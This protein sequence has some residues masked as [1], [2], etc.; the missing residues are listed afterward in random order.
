[1]TPL[2]LQHTRIDGLPSLCPH[3]SLDPSNH[4]PRPN[5]VAP[6]IRSDCDRSGLRI[7]SVPA[8]DVRRRR[9]TE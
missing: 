7:R 1:M 4:R 5:A 2:E 8:A 6:Q 9:P 3:K